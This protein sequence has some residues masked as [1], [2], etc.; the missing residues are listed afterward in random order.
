M[1][2]HLLPAL[3]ILLSLLLALALLSNDH[4]WGDDWAAYVM[5]AE[6]ILR[7]D[8]QEF[9]RRNAFTTRTSTQFLGPDAYPWGYPTLMAPWV[10]LCGPHNFLCLKW[11]NP[12]CYALFLIVLYHLLARRLPPF[13]TTLL[14][15]VFA[16][17]PTLLK[18]NDHLLSEIAFLFLS[19]L[20]LLLIDDVYRGPLS[21]AKSLALGA[22]LFLAFFVR[23]NGILLVPTLFVAQIA[24]LA[25]ADPR[26]L[27]S[28][29]KRVRPAQ[30]GSA[31][32]GVLPYLVF[33]LLA[34]AN[35][36]IFPAGEGSHLERLRIVSRQTLTDNLSAYLIMASQFFQDLRFPQLIYGILLPFV[37]GGMV[38]Q[39][40][41]EAHLIAY[42]VLSYG[43]FILWPA[44]QGVRFL[45]PLLPILVYFAYRG[46]EATAFA[47]TERHRTLG[48]WLTILFWLGVIV[49]FAW[50]SV[51]LAGQ[52]LARGRGHNGNV[53]DPLSLEMFAFVRENTPP[54]G[55]IAFYKPRALRLFTDRN[56]L[57]IHDCDQ[58][59][60]ADYAVLRKSRGGVDQVSPQTIETCNPALQV[61][62]VFENHKFVVY[63]L[64]PR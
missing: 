51:S 20:G 39:A 13:P 56:A 59:P 18:F 26:R 27:L 50:A 11:I 35:F 23:T 25:L 43:L 16:V 21:L 62:R 42:V 46:M 57:L 32:S 30:A 60:L 49:I 34:L 8:L 61:T 64:A 40:R 38:L 24:S 44:Q 22:A 28:D 5:Q 7:G 52:N 15:A 19:T 17:S 29:L 58:L 10:A 1:K 33:F 3:L 55:V 63:R 41:R 53:L 14:L 48:R 2:R 31:W 4:E 12:I 54:D 37:L 36:L 6:A 9:I 45:F 47:L